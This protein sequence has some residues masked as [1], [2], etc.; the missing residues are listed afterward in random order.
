LANNSAPQ[1]A[2]IDD[3]TYAGAASIDRLKTEWDAVRNGHGKLTVAH[4]SKTEVPTHSVEMRKVHRIDG[5]MNLQFVV[6]HTRTAI[7]IICRPFF[8]KF[9]CMAERVDKQNIHT[10]NTEK[11]QVT[12]PI[13]TS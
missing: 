7:W 5:E 1:N 9:A 10:Q 8:E 2:G 6:H 4:V 13:S 3:G 11:N 12:L